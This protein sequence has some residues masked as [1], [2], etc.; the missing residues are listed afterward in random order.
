MIGLTT[1]VGRELRRAARRKLL[2]RLRVGAASAGILLSLVVLFAQFASGSASNPG[3]YMFS[4]MV[5][6]ACLFNLMAGPLFAADTISGEK[7]EGTLGLLMLTPLR[8]YEVLSGKFVSL[9]LPGV[10]AM[11]AMV[12]VFGLSFFMGGVAAAEFGRAFLVLVLTL[13][14][15]LSVSLACSCLARHAVA[16]LAGSATIL[17]ALVALIPFALYDSATKGL[18]AGGV[19]WVSPVH[20]LELVSTSRYAA[21]PGEFWTTAGGLL[22]VSMVS[23]LGGGVVLRRSWREGVTERLRTRLRARNTARRSRLFE[24]APLLWLAHHTQAPARWTWLL[25]LVMVASWMICGASWQEELF[26]FGVLFALV[27]LSNGVLKLWIAWLA[28]H[29]RADDRRSGALEMLCCLPVPE[30]S[31]WGS[32]LLHLKQRLLAPVTCLILAEAFLVAVAP[33]FNGASLDEVLWS[34][35]VFL[36]FTVFLLADGY[37]LSWMGIS[38]SLTFTNAGRALATTIGSVLL[39]PGVLVMIIVPSFWRSPMVMS[40][41]PAMTAAWACLGIAINI[42]VCALAAASL[43]HSFRDRIARSQAP[44][45][46]GRETWQALSAA[47]RRRPIPTPEKLAGSGR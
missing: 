9:L 35:V 26:E 39:V 18:R 20:A 37:T 7:R 13:L 47:G 34:W 23:L 12:P 36:V 19:A 21:N 24:D 32:W 29:R 27:Y 5:L 1:I 3:R 14:L 40:Y 15:S 28:T 22:L 46:T 16:G 45:W 25:L 11:L 42:P 31:I 8:Y 4:A 6:L 38:S 33:R 43:S 2:H 17:L 44:G 30:R 41:L 10:Q